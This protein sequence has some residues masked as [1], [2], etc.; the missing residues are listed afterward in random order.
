MQESIIPHCN[1][2]RVFGL[3][4]KQQNMDNLGADPGFSGG[5]LA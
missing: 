1:K 5:G 3:A 4:L 2:V